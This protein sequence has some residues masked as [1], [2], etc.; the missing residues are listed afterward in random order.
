MSSVLYLGAGNAKDLQF[1]VIRCTFTPQIVLFNFTRALE[2]H[3][4]YTAIESVKDGLVFSGKYEGG[5]KI[6]KSPHVIV[7]SNWHPDVT[8]LTRDRWEIIQ[9]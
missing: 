3:V 5:T 4:S 9:L 7:F 8:Q 6:F 2:G 1:Q